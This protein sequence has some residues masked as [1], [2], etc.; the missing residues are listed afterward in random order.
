MTFHPSL[1]VRTNICTGG[2]ARVK[3]EEL[4]ARFLGPAD[5]AS[6]SSEFDTLFIE[7]IPHLSFS[8]R[9]QARRFITLVDELYNHGVRAVVT[10]SDDPDALFSGTATDAPILDLES[11]QFETAVEG[12]RLRRDLTKEAS[13]APVVTNQEE[14]AKAQ[15]AFGGMEEKFAFARAV[16]RL[17]EMQSPVYVSARKRTGI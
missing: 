10:A 17:Y 2:A 16:S 11:L 8:K 3:F 5:Y 7:G 14:K 15:A 9:D 12:S 13:V 4:C 1:H 6:I